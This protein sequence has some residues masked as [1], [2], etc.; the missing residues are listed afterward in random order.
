MNVILGYFP[1]HIWDVIRHPL[2]KSIIFQRGRAQ[3]PT[4]FSSMILPDFP[5]GGGTG[6]KALCALE[7]KGKGILVGLDGENNDTFYLNI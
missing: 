2:T 6:I 4:R 7:G 1:F 3:P 5:A